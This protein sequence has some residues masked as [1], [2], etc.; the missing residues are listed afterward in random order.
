MNARSIVARLD[1]QVEQAV[2]HGDVGARAAGARW[3]SRL[4]AVGVARGS[5]TTSFGGFGPARRSRTRTQ[6]TVCGRGHVVADQE[7]AVGHVEVGVRAG[8][9]VA[10]R[11]SRI[12]AGAAVAVQSRV[13]P[14]MCGVPMPAL[15]M[16]RERVILL[17]EEL[18]GV[19]EAD[20]PPA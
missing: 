13:L 17:E 7:Q 8:L 12:S 19:V 10:R 16:T 4:G 9:A 15:A 18:A 20:G 6:S 1:E 11:T 3:T 2:E 14:S 5:T